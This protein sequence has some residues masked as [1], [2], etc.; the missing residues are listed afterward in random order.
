MKHLGGTVYDNEGYIV[1]LS[2]DD[3]LIIERVIPGNEYTEFYPLSIKGKKYIDYTKFLS[4]NVI[5]GK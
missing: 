3:D 1:W 4:F 2:D 5:G